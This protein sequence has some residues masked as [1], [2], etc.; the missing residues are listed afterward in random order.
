[1]L[2]VISQL[3]DTHFLSDTFWGLPLQMNCVSVD[4][5]FFTA[6][7]LG[8]EQTNDR[9]YPDLNR[10]FVYSP[11][12]FLCRKDLLQYCAKFCLFIPLLAVKFQLSSV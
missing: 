8:L 1:M 10:L 12:F 6:E 4:L 7:Q 2:V 9:S 3:T 11:D 5:D